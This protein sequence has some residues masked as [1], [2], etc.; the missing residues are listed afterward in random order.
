MSGRLS[1][2]KRINVGDMDNSI[3][4][5]TSGKFGYFLKVTDTVFTASESTIFWRQYIQ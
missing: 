4:W 3:N 2:G 1:V 5:Y